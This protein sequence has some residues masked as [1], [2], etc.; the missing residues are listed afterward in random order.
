MT[1]QTCFKKPN[2][3][4][5]EKLNWHP[6]SRQLEQFLTVQRL[7]N[8]YNAEVNLTRLIH[9]EDYWIGQ[10]FDSLWPLQ[11]E[12][13]HQPEKLTCIDVGTGCGFPG[14]AIAIGLTKASITLVDSTKKKTRILKEISRELGLESRINV[15]TER[16]ESTGQNKNYRGTYDLAIARAVADAPVVAEYLIPLIN[17]S[18]EALLFKGN[19]CQIDSQNLTKTLENLNASIAE[20]QSIKL[21]SN[22]GKRHLIRLKAQGPCPL[23]YPRSIGIPAKKPLGL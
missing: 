15:L 18:G 23:F 7:L 16:I 5:W 21:P 13:N 14:L 19:W 17:Q 12:L 1:I 3:S 4:L 22:R 20:I 2:P 9:G 6:S 11:T 10:I 8:H